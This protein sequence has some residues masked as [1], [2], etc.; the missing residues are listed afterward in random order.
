MF[1]LASFTGYLNLF[2]GTSAFRQT[3]RV[4][5]VTSSTSTMTYPILGSFTC[6]VSRPPKDGFKARRREHKDEARQT[7]QAKAILDKTSQAKAVL[8]QTRQDKTRQ[9][10]DKTTPENTGQHTTSKV[11]AN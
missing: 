5:S 7:R 10:R 11:G 4:D 6:I 1:A 3:M 9:R 2:M 8:D